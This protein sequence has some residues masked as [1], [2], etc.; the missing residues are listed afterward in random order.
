MKGLSMNKMLGS[1]KRKPTLRG[2]QN[3]STEDASSIDPSAPGETPETIVTRCVKAFCESGRG[4]ASGDEVTFLPPIVD[5][6]ESSPA[7]AAEAARLIRKYFNR[8]YWTKPSYQYNSIMLLRILA[9]NPGPTFT[10]NIDKKF[11]EAT[12]ELLRGGRDPSVRQILME[13]LDTFET[14]KMYDEGLLNIIEMWK[15]E[16]EKAYKAY[17]GR[18]VPA[19]AAAPQGLNANAPFHD[20]HSQNYFS[21]SH[22]SKRLPDPVELANRLEEARTSAKLLEQVVACTPPAEILSNDLIKEF[23]DRCLSASRSLQGYMTSTNP[24]PDNETMESMIDTNEQLQSALS[25]HQRAVLN[26]RK[27]LG[28]GERSNNHT[29]SNDAMYEG[30]PPGPPSTWQNPNA[31]ASSSRSNLNSTPPP[32][33]QKRLPSPPSGKGKGP[34]GWEPSPPAGPSR[35]TNGTP[36]GPPPSHG[37]GTDRHS[38]ENEDPFRDPTPEPP[39]GGGGGWRPSGTDS[40]N[41]PPR[42][43]VDSFHPGF[44]T[45]PTQ[46]YLGRQDSA[47]DNLH[48]HGASSAAADVV[49]PVSEGTNTLPPG[50]LGSQTEAARRYDVDDEDDDRYDATPKKEGHVF[51]Y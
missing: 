43:A 41:Q 20:P 24:T 10:R 5:A 31:A 30:G 15:K 17:G 32:T 33:T 9:D 35:S 11:V 23:A 19:A 18:P 7:A 14:Q 46:S 26:A 47:V 28:V 42:L 48:M 38:E 3:G 49:S 1:I 16:K 12:K 34:A 45:G 6:A 39:R 21:R 50:G 4:N 29:P 36:P 22:S 44:G 25:Q 13:T 37:Y 27:H 2:P 8:D 51:R 40:S